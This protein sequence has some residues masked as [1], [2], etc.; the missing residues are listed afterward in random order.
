MFP[1]D[2]LS[3]CQPGSNTTRKVRICSAYRTNIVMSYVVPGPS[4]FNSSNIKGMHIELNSRFV[5]HAKL[6][7][8]IHFHDVVTVSETIMSC[9]PSQMMYSETI[10]RQKSTCQ[11]SSSTHSPRDVV[12]VRSTF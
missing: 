8:F 4:M 9:N 11:G 2:S 12:Y 3:L 5:L 7:H 6:G 1:L 10:S